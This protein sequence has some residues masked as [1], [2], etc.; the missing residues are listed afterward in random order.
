MSRVFWK[1]K[2]KMALNDLI[3]NGTENRDRWVPN[4][5]AHIDA[6]AFPTKQGW[7][8][9]GVRVFK[10]AI[11]QRDEIAPDRILMMEFILGLSHASQPGPLA[12]MLRKTSIPPRLFS[13]SPQAAQEQFDRFSDSE[14]LEHE[15]LGSGTELEGAPLIG[16]WWTRYRFDDG[17]YE[18][19]LYLAA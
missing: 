6:F 5:G 12:R 9:T 10:E 7:G 1:N 14:K 13:L 15:K 3:I 17:S 2:P 8:T 4:E 18:V 16:A 19:A 11:R